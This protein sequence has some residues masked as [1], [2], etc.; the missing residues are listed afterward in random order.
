MHQVHA[1]HKACRVTRD[2]AAAAATDAATTQ[3][4][5]Q[6]IA[7]CSQ[8]WLSITDELPPH[9]RLT[10]AAVHVAWRN[11]AALSTTALYEVQCRSTSKHL[12]YA[13]DHGANN[14]PYAGV[15]TNRSPNGQEVCHAQPGASLQDVHH[16]SR[17]HR[18][19]CPSSPWLLASAW[20]QKLLQPRCCC[21][22]RSC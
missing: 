7:Q 12:T 15:C 9:T 3:L 20:Q 5:L 6:H 21:C 19:C 4:H 13:S 1:C 17:L 18:S 8:R 22:R 10:A 14:T 11:T 16:H 2:A